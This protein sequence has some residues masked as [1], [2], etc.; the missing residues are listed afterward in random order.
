MGKIVCILTLSMLISG[1]LAPANIKTVSHQER[2]WLLSGQALP[3][4]NPADLD[5]KDERVLYVTKDMQVFAR[6]AV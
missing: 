1:C 5:L 2:Q 3:E 4:V 6:K